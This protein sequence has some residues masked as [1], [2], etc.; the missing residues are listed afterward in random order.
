MAWMRIMG[1]KSVGYHEHT[2]LERGDDAVANALEYHASPA[3][4]WLQGSTTHAP[5][6][7]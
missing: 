4:P 6:A 2:V 3:T 5:D 1:A 7:P